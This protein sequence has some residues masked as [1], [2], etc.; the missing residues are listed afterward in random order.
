MFKFTIRDVLW[1][2]VVIALAVLWGKERVSDYLQGDLW[3]RRYNQVQAGLA[4][5]GL[6]VFEESNG[7]YVVGYLKGDPA[8]PV[9]PSVP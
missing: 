2:M 3:T 6:S 1:L 9:G 5:H 7:D 4:K 8:I